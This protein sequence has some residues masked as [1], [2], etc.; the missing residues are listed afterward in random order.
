MADLQLSFDDVLLLLGDPAAAWLNA[1][2]QAAQHA[3]IPL[4]LV[5]GTVRDLLLHRANLDLDF[6]V[7]GDAI[8]F[9][10]H[11]QTQFGGSITAHP[12]FG[13]AT[14]QI[15]TQAF[16]LATPLIVDFASA[17]QETYAY[18]GALPTVTL[19]NNI[20]TDLARRDFTLNALAYTLSPPSQLGQIIDPF[21]GMADLEGRVL[22][23]L[24]DESF[25]DDPTRILRGYR[26]CARLQAT[27][28]VHTQTLIPPALPH[29][30]AVSGERIRH[31]FDLLLT[32]A[33]PE[34][35]LQAMDTDGVL[36]AIHPAFQVS[37]AIL[38]SFVRLQETTVSL[39]TRVATLWHVLA[40]Q[41]ATTAQLDQS[42]VQTWSARLDLPAILQNSIL[43]WLGAVAA[44]RQLPLNA[45]PSALARIFRPL[46]DE[47][48]AAWGAVEP[49]KATTTAL[50]RFTVDWRF[51]QRTTTG[52]DLKALGLK[53]GPCYSRL[54]ERLTDARIDDDVTTDAEEHDLLLQLIRNGFCN[55]GS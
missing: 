10:Q 1:I 36:H 52:D 50:A 38:R 23:V 20:E 11:M 3:N 18:P 48:L 4:Y 19:A 37:D 31:E 47:A 16:P 53:P 42:I 22:R 30:D 8:A 13:T 5:G 32:Q 15:S 43:R 25:I 9:A 49:D 54:L 40:Y 14:W 34:A 12:P 24:H 17:R 55:D 33:H 45:P 46:T 2:A 6:V 44:I 39:E 27:F 41:V 26:Y 28:D 29:F 35:V 51:R 7:V 21:G